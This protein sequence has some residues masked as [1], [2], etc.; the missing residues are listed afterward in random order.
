MSIL[1]LYSLQCD[2]HHCLT[3][4]PNASSME[5]LLEYAV[6]HGWLAQGKK[7]T[8]PRCQNRRQMPGEDMGGVIRDRDRRGGEDMGR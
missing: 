6:Q 5:S 1:Q 4:T 3:R 7:H 8:C 2:G